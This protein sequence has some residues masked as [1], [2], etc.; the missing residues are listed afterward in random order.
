MC[1]LI[2]EIAAASTSRRRMHPICRCCRCGAQV[3]L[4]GSVWRS[5]CITSTSC[6]MMSLCACKNDGA[7]ISATDARRG[8]IVQLRRKI[9]GYAQQLPPTISAASGYQPHAF[10]EGG[11]HLAAH[12]DPQRTRIA[13]WT[14]GCSRVSARRCQLQ[15]ASVVPARDRA[16]VESAA[17]VAC[18]W[19]G[20]ISP[21]RVWPLTPS[22]LA[23]RPRSQSRRPLTDGRFLNGAAV[24]G[25]RGRASRYVP[26]LRHPTTAARALLLTEQVVLV[27]GRSLNTHHRTKAPA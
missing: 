7:G 16:R 19:V 25:R 14:D 18:R 24:R 9:F 13:G 6:N 12:S 4:R 3:C 22:A 20:C 26:S 8:A 15:L 5:L 23:G 27:A 2:V 17:H 11:P 21:I 1:S 10:R